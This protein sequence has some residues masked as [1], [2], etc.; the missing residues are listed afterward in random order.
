[1]VG[2]LERF[3]GETSDLPLRFASGGSEVCVWGCGAGAVP[4]LPAHV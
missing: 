4:H 2:S 3:V 1:M